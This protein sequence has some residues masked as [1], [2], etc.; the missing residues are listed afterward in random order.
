[1]DKDL[2]STSSDSF[3]L[4]FSFVLDELNQIK[5]TMHS[6]QRTG[7]GAFALSTNLAIHKNSRRLFFK[8]WWPVS[9]FRN[10]KKKCG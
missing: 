3:L 2:L 7:Y 9:A 8:V 10:A 6:F 1:M 5:S 4:L